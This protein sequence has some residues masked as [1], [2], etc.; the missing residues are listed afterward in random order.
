MLFFVYQ[1][2]KNR[3]VIF[4]GPILTLEMESTS[5]SIIRQEIL[6]LKIYIQLLKLIKKKISTDFCL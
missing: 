6:Q 3:K 1:R 4:L 5:E 2:K